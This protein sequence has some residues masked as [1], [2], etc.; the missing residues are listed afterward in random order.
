MMDLIN[1][2]ILERGTL[3]GYCTSSYLLTDTLHFIVLLY[4][5]SILFII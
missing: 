5:L 2:E 3:P 4:A 1:T